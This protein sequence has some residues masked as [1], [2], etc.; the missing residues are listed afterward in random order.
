[1]LYI[2]FAL[3]AIPEMACFARNF[4]I[5]SLQSFNFWTG[6]ESLKSCILS[7]GVSSTA[8]SVNSHLIQ[9]MAIPGQYLLVS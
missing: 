9:Y 6:I 8:S 7:R 4:C 5:F 3:K 2:A 1:M